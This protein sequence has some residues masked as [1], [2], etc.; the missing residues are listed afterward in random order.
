MLVVLAAIGATSA[1][2][3]QPQVP[4]YFLQGEQLA[5]VDRPGTTPLDAVRARSP[6]R[7]GPRS[8]GLSD[9]RAD[10]HAG[11]Q[12]GGR[13]RRR[14]RRP[15]RAIR[16]GKRPREPARAAVPARPHADGA[17]GRNE[18]A[19]P[20][21][22]RVVAARFPGSRRATR[23]VPL[24]ADAE[25]SR[26]AAAAAE[27]PGAGCRRE[28]APAAPDRARLPAPRRRRRPL[29]TGDPERHP[30]VPEMGAAR[31][32]RPAGRPDEGAA[33]DRRAPGLRAARAGPASVPRSCST[34]RSRC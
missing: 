18:G 16:V 12:R 21:E 9:V 10:G 23:S 31:P 19:A 13:E 24:P 27:A 28:E 15:E 1:T 4:V 6:A 11:A 14:D 7:R 30:R 17:A 22:R 33:R 25:R 2:T 3:A 5:R 34:A 32:D 8:H 20:D 26:A 29:R